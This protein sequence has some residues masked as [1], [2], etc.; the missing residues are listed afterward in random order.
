MIEISI[1]DPNRPERPGPEPGNTKEFKSSLILRSF[2][3]YTGEVFKMVF[4]VDTGTP[5]LIQ[6]DLEGVPDGYTYIMIS[7]FRDQFGE[8]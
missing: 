5:Y 3:G 2:N 6:P 8:L 1:K 4:D 7:V